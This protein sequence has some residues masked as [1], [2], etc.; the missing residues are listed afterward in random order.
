MQGE[1]ALLQLTPLREVKAGTQG[2]S[3]E[4]ETEA[5]AMENHCLLACF[6]GFLSLL[7]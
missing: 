5:G 2:R 3:I 7:S 4:A 1:K 6:H